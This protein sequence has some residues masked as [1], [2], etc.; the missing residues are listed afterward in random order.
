MHLV[1]PPRCLTCDAQVVTQGTFCGDCWADLPLISQPYC[2]RTGSP[3]SY[4][5]GAGVLSA[6][7]LVNPP[8][9]NKMRA[10]TL[11]EGTARKLVLSLKFNDRLDLAK[12]MAAFMVN[13]GRSIL[14]AADIIVPVPL[15]RKRLVSRRFNQA[16]QLAKAMSYQSGI[17]LAVNALTRIRATQQQTVLRFEERRQNVAG[18]FRVLPHNAIKVKGRRVVLVDDVYTTGATISACVRALLREQATNV[19]VIT[20]AKVVDTQ[21]I[22]I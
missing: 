20:F 10:P 17:P 1:L 22:H 7:A 18:A 6:D 8:L 12:P 3:F 11:Y 21:E 15:H 16:G 19:D 14:D 2:D 4:D 13:T 5:L 9:Y